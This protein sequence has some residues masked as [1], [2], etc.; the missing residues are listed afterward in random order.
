MQAAPPLLCARNE[1]TAK[2][3]L[4]N[5]KNYPEKVGRLF[6]GGVVLVVLLPTLTLH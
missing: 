3:L 6:Q 1:G 5:I 2:E 4:E